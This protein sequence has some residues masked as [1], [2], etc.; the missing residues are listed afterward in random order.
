MSKLEV[1][2]RASGGE[3]VGTMRLSANIV[4]AP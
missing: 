4:I 3:D 1:H 2:H